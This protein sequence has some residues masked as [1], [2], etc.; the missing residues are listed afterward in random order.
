VT[1]INHH[2]QLFPGE[3]GSRQTQFFFFFLTCADL[4][5]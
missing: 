3:M 2:V 4:E 5:L 1:G